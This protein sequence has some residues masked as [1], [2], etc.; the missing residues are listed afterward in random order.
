MRPTASLLFGGLLFL[1]LCRFTVRD[2]AFV[3]LDDPGFE[4]S[5][6][7]PA[8]QEAEAESL[9]SLAKRALADSNV[10]PKVFVAGET[11]RAVLTIGDRSLDLS[12][13]GLGSKWLDGIVDSP[14]RKKIREETVVDF[15][16]VILSKGTDERQNREAEAAIDAA[17]GRLDK[18]WG[19]MPKDVGHPPYVLTIADGLRDLDGILL[20]SLGLSPKPT[21]E[22][23][24]AVVFG[25]GRRVGPT[26]AGDGITEQ[27][28]FAILANVGKSCECDLDRSWM[29]GPRIPLRWDDAT[30]KRAADALDFDPDSPL[31]KS[32]IDDI[33]AQGPGGTKRSNQKP[34]DEILL[35]YSEEVGDEPEA[36]A[37]PVE[38]TARTGA[39]RPET[40]SPA[41]NLIYALVTILAVSVMGGA[42]ILLRGRR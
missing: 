23:E 26:L 9:E 19:K 28:V 13:G 40:P 36:T 8:S 21:P 31:V 15:C 32:E 7:L 6:T 20:W 34:I 38:A 22:P 16:V 25:R 27:S 4:L 42:T 41:H 2:V 30:R 18:V 29:R 14:L 1:P 39:D 10:V 37:S 12:A 11:T 5:I 3:D 33:L 35:G 17:F 24:V